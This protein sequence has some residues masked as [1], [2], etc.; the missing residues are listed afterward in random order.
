MKL[1]IKTYVNF[2][3]FRESINFLNFQCES[4][5]PSVPVPVSSASMTNQSITPSA[6][7]ARP[8]HAI[9]KQEGLFV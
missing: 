7:L 4:A 1:N 6:V 3:N 8:Q 5:S 2:F 9:D